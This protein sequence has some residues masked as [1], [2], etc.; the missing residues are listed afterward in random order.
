VGSIETVLA[1]GTLKG[2]VTTPE[3]Q[4]L[5]DVNLQIQ[6]TSK[7]TSTDKQGQFTLT[8]I[9]SGT[10]QVVISRVGY[11]RKQKAVAVEE[12]ATETLTISL[13]QTAMRLDQV[14]FSGSPVPR[15]PIESTTDVNLIAGA[16]KFESESAGIGATVDET[17]G[18][19]S[20]NTGPQTSKP[21]IRGLKG[22][23]IRMLHNNIGTDYQQYGI[24]HM[25]NMDPY[26]ADRLEVVQGPASVLYGSN[27]MGGAV[28]YL[29]KDIE[30][31][32]ERSGYLRGSVMGS[33]ATNNDGVNTGLTLEGATGNWGF[34]AKVIRR[35]GDNI[36]TGE[37]DNFKATGEKGDPKFTGELDNTDFEQLNG[38]GTIGY[39]GDFGKVSLNYTRWQNEHNFLL[40]NGKGLGQRLTN[41]TIQG[42]ADFELDEENT[43]RTTFS[44]ISNQRQS[45]K[46]GTTRSDMADLDDKAHLDILRELYS[47]RISLQHQKVGPLQGQV[48]AEVRSTDQTTQGAKEPLVPS[49]DILNIGAF[50]YEEAVYGPVT[51]SLGG[52]FDYREQT[53]K[54]N[55]TLNLAADDEQDFSTVSGNFGVNY[56]LM[57]ELA[58]IANVGRGF[59]A[60]GVFDLHVDGQH[61]GI[62]AY[63]R[64][65]SDLQ[66]ESSLN[67]DLSVRWQSSAL[68]AKATV[69]R[70]LI[71]DYIFLSSTGKEPAGGGPTIWET[72]QGDAELLGGYASIAW[73]AFNN[74]TVK[75]SAQFVEGTNQG[76]ID[77]VDEL[78]MIPANEGEFELKYNRS[79]LGPLKGF[80]ITAGLRHAM[81]KDAAGRYE[82]FSQFDFAKPFGKASTDAYTLFDAGI[83]GH[84][85][86]QNRRIHFSIKGLNLT[87]KAYRNFMDTYKGYALSPGRNIRIKVRIPFQILSADD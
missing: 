33:Y 41:N 14:V 42:Q 1:Q 47:G 79:A 69:Y 20:V 76:D 52:R 6:G 59:R 18:V 28:N 82:P 5:A 34:E 77:D 29:T 84:I 4:G 50:F 32:T 70:N 54:E 26:L 68:Q 12:G 78:P 64:G 31:L 63:Q 57:E 85:P 61:G 19:R 55:A 80:F 66:P 22:K 11:K 49:A 43:L 74:L 75:A 48:G 7:G 27:A 10:Q 8:D 71:N 73:D 56:R 21:V 2:T 65:R 38:S 23:R 30:Q 15:A 44:Y 40:P 35:S 60:P 53:A 87:D 72:Q 83:G 86:F 58:L 62:A 9:P 16:N 67:T 37:A 45:A 39:D 51:L 36:T 24:R 46:E 13:P 81:A 17:P 3:G 25:P